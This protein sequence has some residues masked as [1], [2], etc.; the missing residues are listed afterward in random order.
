ML[1]PLTPEEMATM[2][3]AARRYQGAWTGT[4]GTLAAHVM[5]LIQEVR[6]LQV[7]AAYRRELRRPMPP[8]N[9]DDRAA[10]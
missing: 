8:L 3:Q 6:R 2:E 5:R 1:E 9:H 10:G 7:E 4:S